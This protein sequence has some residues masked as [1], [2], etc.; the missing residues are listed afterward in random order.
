[1]KETFASELIGQLIRIEGPITTGKKLPMGYGV[2]V[3][4][5]ESGLMIENITRIWIEMEAGEPIQAGIRL[6]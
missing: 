4:L 2:K 5:A 1:M 6:A 3:T